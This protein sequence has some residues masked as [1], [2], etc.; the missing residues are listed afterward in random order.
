M[1][2]FWPWSRDDPTTDALRLIEVTVPPGATVIA[3]HGGRG[4]AAALNEAVSL[5]GRADLVI[6]ADAS[7]LPDG[8]VPRLREAAQIDDAVAASTAL[9]AGG[10]EH[11]FAGSDGDPVY[12]PDA[13]AAGADVGPGRPVHPRIST[14]FPHC[15]YIRRAAVELVGPFDESLTHPRA[16]LSE[17]AARALS[18]GLSC[19][20]ADDVQVIVREGGLPPCPKP[21][22][23]KVAELH[24]W[25][26]TVRREEDALELGPLRRS[27]VAARVAGAPL[28]VTID[29]RALGPD[30]AGTQ[31]YVAGLVL[32]LGRSEGVSVRAVLRDDAPAE[33][34]AEFEREGIEAVTER[35]AARGLARTDIAHRPQQAF[36]P[37]DL[38]LLRKLGERVVITHLDLISYR[39]PTYHESP[40]EWRRYR[41]LTRLALGAVDRVVFLSEHGRRDAIAEDLIEPAWTAVAGVGV[42]SAASAELPRQPRRVPSGRALL[43]MIGSDYLHKN[44]IFA[45]ELVDELRKRHGWDGML[46]LAGAHVAHGGSAAAEAELLGA[47]PQLAAHVLDLGPIAEDEKRWL[48]QNARAVLCPSTYEGFGLTPLE[49]AAAGTACLYAATTSLAEVV[50]SESATIVAWDA[51]ASADLAFPLLSDGD[52]RD[53]HLAGLR[54]ALARYR[55]EPIVEELRRLYRDALASPYRSSVPRA[56]EDLE[57]EQLIAVLDRGYHDLRERVDHGLPLIDRGGLLTREQQRGLMRIAARRWL[58]GPLLGPVGLL[59]A[60]GSD[61]PGASSS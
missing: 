44:R 26:E 61:D 42:D 58:R 3:E 21:E 17:F 45:L 7:T 57:R 9:A 51:A 59:G 33:I 18:R 32:A 19:T 48:L 15:S 14:L 5:G 40:D 35:V 24:P 60:A 52:E 34:V 55:W 53:R 16:V 30:A 49:A 38:R 25:F 11:V 2:V 54:A 50:G 22:M 13:A 23:A 28:S 4:F 12:R 47:R 31:T 46:V 43:V 29:A 37:E 36:V 27:L 10:D 20:L 41:R 39:N 56:W 8:W 1:I 6:V